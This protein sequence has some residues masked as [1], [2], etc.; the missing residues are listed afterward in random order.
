MN[1]ADVAT[2]LSF[3]ETCDVN[4]SGRKKEASGI[5]SPDK[6]MQLTGPAFLLSA[7]KRRYSRPGN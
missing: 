4:G 5:N 1:V 6:R 3:K 2:I 7:I